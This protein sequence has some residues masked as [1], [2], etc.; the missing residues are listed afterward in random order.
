MHCVGDGGR[1]GG[2]GVVLGSWLGLGRGR[3]GFWVV[4][5]VV[6]G[7]IVEVAVNIRRPNP[8]VVRVVVRVFALFR[9]ARHLASTR[10]LVVPMES[11]KAMRSLW[12]GGRLGGAG[13]SWLGVVIL[14]EVVKIKR[15]DGTIVG[16]LLIVVTVVGALWIVGAVVGAVGIVGTVVGAVGIVGTVVGVIGIVN[17]VRRAR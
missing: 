1:L 7:V 2:A 17:V 8:V 12:D 16:A 4:V 6:V 11:R 13:C 10:H 5:E 3:C 15:G 9:P 14:E